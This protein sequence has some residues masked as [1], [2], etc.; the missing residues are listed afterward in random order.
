MMAL[1]GE[2]R[3]MAQRYD[4]MSH[5]YGA[6]LPVMVTDFGQGMAQPILRLRGRLARMSQR[7]IRIEAA[8]LHGHARAQGLSVLEC[9]AQQ[10][11]RHMGQ[12]GG[13]AIAMAYLDVMV[14]AAK[15]PDHGACDGQAENWLALVAVRLGD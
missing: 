9:L 15:I 10:M 12:G 3:L 6:A 8:Q 11:M 13:R 1:R 2:V 14:D 4:A 7:Q 5:R